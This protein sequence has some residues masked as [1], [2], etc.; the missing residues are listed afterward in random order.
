LE[1]YPVTT[2]GSAVR[3]ATEEIKEV[4]SLDETSEQH[5]AIAVSTLRIYV[6]DIPARKHSFSIP[7]MWGGPSWNSFDSDDHLGRSPCSF[8]RGETKSSSA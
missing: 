6:A 5:N 7:S 1:M 8:N 3:T 2:M 4:A